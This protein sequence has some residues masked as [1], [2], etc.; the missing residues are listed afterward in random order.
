MRRVLLIAGFVVLFLLFRQSI[1]A[2]E[3]DDITHEL[4]NLGRALQSSQAAT[5]TNVKQHQTLQK[6]LD[7]IRARVVSLGTQIKKKEEEVKE[8]EVSLTQQKELLDERTVSHYKNIGNYQFSVLEM[9]MSQN[10]SEFI[11]N[12]HYQE[13]ILNEDQKTIVKT[14]LYIKDLEEKKLKLEEE[15]KKLAVI[16][17]EVDRQSSFL[18]KEIEKSKAYEGELQK[19]IASLT[20]RQQQI[21]AQKLAGLN[22][23]RSAASLMGGCTDDRSVDPGFSPRFAF[24]TYGV[25]NRVGMNQWGAYGRSRAGQDYKTIL[26]AYYKNVRFECRSFPGNSIQVK[27]YGS[28]NIKDYL[29]GLGEM[30]SSWGDSGGYEAFKAQ[31]VAAASYAYTY[32]G[33]GGKEI[34]TSESCQVYIGSNKGGKWDQA[35]NDATAMCGDGVEVMVSNDT[36]EVIS[37]WYS[38][39]FGGYSR[40]SGDAWGSTK[41]WTQRMRDTSGDVSSFSDLQ[42]NAYDKDSPWFYC[43]WGSRA[44]YNK[45]AW[46]KPAEVADIA[47]VLLLAKADSSVQN[48]LAQTDKPNPDGVE[49]WSADKVRSELQNRGITPLTSVSSVSIGWDQGSGSTNSVSISGDGGSHTFSGGEFKNYFNLRA[50]ASIQIVGDLYNVEKQ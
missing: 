36:N 8:G 39:T 22:I 46:L 48:H 32:T 6:Q 37:A 24:F 16:K 20:A 18:A 13:S 23:P 40:T 35:V 33:G 50:P 42:N 28:V 43:D 14:V 34:C 49:T 45:T 25:P 11:R 30:F 27:G 3:Y 44:E 17:E 47:N 5:Q 4:A 38:S 41:P 2:D 1:V 29:K 21:L 7:G 12:L 9:L 31:V 26:N 10:L 19:K 15:T